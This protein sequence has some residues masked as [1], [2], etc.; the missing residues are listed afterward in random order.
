MKYNIATN[1]SHAAAI[2][3][4]AI[5][6]SGPRLRAFG[7]EWRVHRGGGLQMVLTCEEEGGTALFSQ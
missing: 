4:A 5:G 3:A 2:G 6:T 7:V 1:E